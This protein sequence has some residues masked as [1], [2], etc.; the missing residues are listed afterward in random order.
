M[1]IPGRALMKAIEMR[2]EGE[3]WEIIVKELQ[4]IITD[5]FVVQELTVD[6]LRYQV[7]KF[8]GEC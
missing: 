7:K 1:K 8:K 2:A 3:T 5:S 4:A 6:R